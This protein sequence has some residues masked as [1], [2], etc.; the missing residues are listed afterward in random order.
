MKEGE[1]RGDI[2]SGE[3]NGSKE[4]LVSRGNDK[5]LHKDEKLCRIFDFGSLPLTELNTIISAWLGEL[6]DFP[7]FCFNCFAGTL[8]L[9][10]LFP[11]LKQRHLDEKRPILYSQRDSSKTEWYFL[12]PSASAFI[13]KRAHLIPCMAPPTR[14]GVGSV[15]LRALSPAPSLPPSP[16]SPFCYQ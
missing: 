9:D 5:K 16:F 11:F 1:G 7:R 8:N 10:L 15:V 4:A 12:P 13:S 2:E 14:A 3:W 6:L